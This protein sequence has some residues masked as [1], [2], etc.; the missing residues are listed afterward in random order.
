MF[1]GNAEF[2][3]RERRQEMV[4][5]AKQRRLIK[6]LQRQRPGTVQKLTNWIGCQL[7]KWGTRLQDQTVSLPP[8]PGTAGLTDTKCC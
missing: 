5:E 8:Q 2:V 7:V 4:R 6:T 3:A 1:P